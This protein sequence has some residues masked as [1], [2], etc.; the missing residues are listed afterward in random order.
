MT[1]LALESVTNKREKMDSVQFTDQETG[2]DA[3]ETTTAPEENQEQS[4]EAQQ[5]EQP[6]EFQLPD[7]FKSVKDLLESYENLEKKF[8]SRQAEEK[9]LLTDSDFDQYTEEYNEN[10]SLS[11]KTYDALAKKGLSRDVVDNYISGQQ[12]KAEQ[13]AN[14]LFELA[15]GEESYGKMTEW[16][17]ETLDDE[18]LKAFDEAIDGSDRLASLAIKG[19]Y[20]S[21][22]KAGGGQSEPNLLQGGKPVAEGG[23]TSTYDMQQDMKDPRYKSGDPAFHAYV[24]GRLRKT[25]L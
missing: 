5:Q 24:E 14:K 23:Y 2:P 20:A 11:D 16:M 4:Q 6:Q 25:N 18:E 13:S 12:L 3:P 8:S 1:I 22:Q 7:K 19:M 9:G 17:R 10:G 21:Y 15:G